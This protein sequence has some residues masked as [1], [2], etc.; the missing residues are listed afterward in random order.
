MHFMP[1]QI[2]MKSEK[3]KIDEGRHQIV[4][5]MGLG[6]NEQNFLILFEKIE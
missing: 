2:A 1:R 5:D 6:T 4:I 3:L